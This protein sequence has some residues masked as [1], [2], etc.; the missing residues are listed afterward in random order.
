MSG[1]GNSRSFGSFGQTSWNPYKSNFSNSSQ[2]SWSSYSKSQPEITELSKVK[3]SRYTDLNNGG[4][5]VRTD[6]SKQSYYSERN[7]K[8]GIIKRVQK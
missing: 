3:Y 1:L 2:T 4:T 8:T 7:Y 5:V 6:S